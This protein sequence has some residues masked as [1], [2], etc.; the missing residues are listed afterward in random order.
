[1]D[2]APLPSTQAMWERA[3]ALYQP[4]SH[5]LYISTLELAS[6]LRQQ[7]SSVNI[8]YRQLTDVWRQLDSLAPAYCRR[9]TVVLFAGSMTVFFA[10]TSFSVVCASSSSSFG[11]AC[12]PLASA[13]SGGGGHLGSS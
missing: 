1:M 13:I 11:S 12:G 9:V 8:F 10:C 2:I 6:S 4:S 5:A 7:D 3:Q